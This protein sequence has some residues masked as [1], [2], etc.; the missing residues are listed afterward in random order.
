MK[1]YITT[2]RWQRVIRNRQN[3]ALR[4]LTRERNSHPRPYRHVQTANTGSLVTITAPSYFSF[5]RNTDVMLEF[6]AQI[7][8]TSRRGNKI[9][10][11]F[12]KTDRITADAIAVFLAIIK[13]EKYTAIYGNVPE[14][15]AARNF[16]SQSGVFK[17]VRQERRHRIPEGPNTGH[18]EEKKSQTVEPETADGLISFATTTLFGEARKCGAAYSTLIECMSNTRDHASKS[19]STPE[20]WWA[21]VYCFPETGAACFTF[22]DCGVGIFNSVKLKP[23]KSLLRLGRITSNSAILKEIFHRKIESSTGLHYRGEGLPRIFDS[24]KR[25]GISNLIVVSNDAYASL[26]TNTY[27]SLSSSFA[28]TVVYWELPIKELQEAPP[29]INPIS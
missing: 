25:G 2:P 7:K 23:L 29:P 10:I 21:T 6:F 13:A 16:F 11:D 17:H 3:R 27:R 15:S 19:I 20:T 8:Q 28:G 18:I 22:I 4:S 5:I 24:M 12:R 26:A 14:D 9:F 1:K